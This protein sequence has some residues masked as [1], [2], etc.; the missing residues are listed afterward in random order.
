[1]LTSCISA[2]GLISVEQRVFNCAFKL[3]AQHHLQVLLPEPVRAL[4]HQRAGV[5]G[6]ANGQSH[7][8]P[9]GQYGQV[10]RGRRVHPPPVLPTQSIPVSRPIPFQGGTV[11]ATLY[12]RQRPIP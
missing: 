8:D 7:P 12:F 4:Q 1:M 9:R 6:L 5:R 3:L 10:D 2:N 11:T